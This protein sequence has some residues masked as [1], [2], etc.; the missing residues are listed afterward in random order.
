MKIAFFTDSYYPRIN[1]VTVSV[2]SYATKLAE[3]GHS[4]CIVCCN[5]DDSKDE[6]T[7]NKNHYDLKDRDI[8]PNMT[9]FRI[10][11]S[12]LV[13]SKEDKVAKLSAWHDVKHAMDDFK[14]DVVHIN[15][16]FMVGY[17]GLLY[18][19]HRNI[20][21]VYTFHTLWE[22]YVEGYIKFFPTYPIKKLA[23]ELIIFFLKRAN[24]II[25]PTKN[26]EKVIRNY[27][28]ERDVKILPTGIP[29]APDVGKFVKPI[30]F[31]Q[32]HKLLPY[33]QKKHILLYVGRVVKEKNLEF[34]FPVFKEVKKTVKDAALVVVGGGPELENLKAKAKKLGIAWEFCFAGYRTKEE[35]AYFY[36]ISDVF[37]FPSKT[38]TQGLVTIEAMMAGLPVVAIGEMGTVDVMQGD[39]GGFMVKDD[40]KEFSDKVV[41]LLTDK[42]LHQQKSAEAKT[43]AQQ[44]S[45]DT[46]TPKLISYYEEAIRIRRE[47]K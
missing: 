17:F 33:I 46:L 26:I 23:K 10:S 15:T 42:N 21:S 40:V 4:V 34:L 3:L 41:Q 39:N 11:S 7:H 36:S 9:I 6:K 35:L 24:V 44:W 30:F 20:P 18:S 25:A 12:V 32:L 28:I 19:R 8:H 29:A 27:K 1:G 5:Y 2:H 14:P 22:E 38:E 13:F 47:G 31:S 37:V 43:W 16:E 45:I